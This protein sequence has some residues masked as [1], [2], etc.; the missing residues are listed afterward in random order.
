MARLRVVERDGVDREA[1]EEGLSRALQGIREGLRRLPVW[2][3]WWPT[4]ERLRGSLLDAL[5]RRR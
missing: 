4:L 5:S 2:S 3:T 1:E